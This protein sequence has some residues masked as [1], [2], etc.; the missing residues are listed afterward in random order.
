MK[1]LAKRKNRMGHA[2]NTIVN[3]TEKEAKL[4]QAIIDA[5]AACIVVLDSDGTIV[6]ANRAWRQFSTRAGSP[7]SGQGIGEIYS[8]HFSMMTSAGYEAKVT[9][10]NGLRQVITGEEI[11]FEIKYRCTAAAEPMWVRAHAAAFIHPGVLKRR[12][13]VVSH[14]ILPVSND[15][16]EPV[17]KSE[18]R[19]GR[20]P[21]D[22]NVMLWE[23]PYGRREFSYAGDKS[24]EFLG[25]SSEDWMLPGF[26]RS[27]L[28]PADSERAAREFSN[29]PQSGCHLNFEYRMLARDGRVVWV[30]D[31]IE[32][33]R[34]FG[35][36]TMIYGLTTDISRRKHAESQLADLSKRLINAQEEERKRIARELHD[37]LNQRMALI[38]I[39]LEQ[40][41][42]KSSEGTTGLPARLNN[43]KRQV[44]EI[45][46]EIHRMS[47]E[48]HPSKLDH[49]GLA[50]AL[51]TF[52]S[53]VEKSRGL[54]V[55]FQAGSMPELP[56]DVTLALF[57]VAQE[58][59]Q[60]AAKHS[61]A[62]R[63]KVQLNSVE[64]T[65]ELIVVDE[66]NGFETSE[67]KMTTGLGLTSMR[68]RVR[69]VGGEFTIQSIP[70]RGT[71]V[72]VVI[73]LEANFQS[74][75]GQR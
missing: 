40:I 1:E 27:R 15:S 71:Q 10:E 48:L 19:S 72:R 9:F 51:R 22:S 2:L 54:R 21:K 13:I 33:V 64:N 69:H 28:F 43:L 17:A 14:D 52:C 4:I 20:F 75:N 61:G 50:P 55:A 23:M 53:D 58:S 65:I 47:Y 32:I 34:E 24:S 5:A 3:D 8:K 45:S 29:M 59:V 41:A 31:Q 49:L 56:R 26:W 39:E 25:F 60:N 16:Q 37:D 57:R 12:M 11:E 35:K 67:E 46:N 42:Q 38:S 44:S 70:T 74:N 6:F 66:G 73:S 36:P 68:E 63:I 30:E 7:G 18:R 62:D